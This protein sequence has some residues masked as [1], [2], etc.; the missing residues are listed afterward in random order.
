M[1][2]PFFIFA[3]SMKIIGTTNIKSL[4][5]ILICS[6][7]LLFSPFLT[8]RW[9]NYGAENVIC[10]DI[11]GYYLY[12]PSFFYDDLGTLT[13]YDSIDK[14]YHPASDAKDMA[15][16]QPQTGK[17]VMN[18]PC[19]QAIVELPAFA[20]GHIWAKL[21]GYEVDGFSFPYQMSITIWC[22]LI[23]CLGLWIMRRLLLK[24]FDDWLVA[25]LIVIICTATNF[26]NFVSFSPATHAYL[27]TIYA[28][29]LYLTDIFYREG[30]YK[31]SIVALIGILSGLATIMRP[32]EIIC[33]IIPL[34]WGVKNMTDLKE[35]LAYFF[36]NYKFVIVYSFCA[37]IA[38]LP[39]LIYWKIYSGH[40]LFF[41][42]HGE[43][44]TFNFLHPH[45]LNVLF[46]YKKGWFMYT[47]V[48][49]I[50][51]IGFIQL[52]K[53]FTQ[54]FWALA[55]FTVVN[56][57]LI[58]SWNIWWYGG[59]FSMRPMVQSYPLLMFP[60]GAFLADILRRKYLQYMVSGFLVFCIWLNLMMT[61]QANVRS[62]MCIMEGESMNYAYYWHIFGKTD[63]TAKDKRLLD[64]NEELPERLETKFKLFFSSDLED[65]AF[66]DSTIALS[67][68]KSIKLT[69]DKQWTEKLNVPVD[70][71]IH[72][73]WYRVYASVYY[74][75]MESDIWLQTQFNA[76][77]YKNGKVVKLNM[78]RIQ[79]VSQQ[80]SWQ[81]VYVDI[82]VPYFSNYD[83]FEINFWN[84]GSAKNIYID[85]IKVAYC[86][87]N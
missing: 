12:L 82:K 26:Y 56:I 8:K 59:C 74:P 49:M 30:R 44:K 86:P 38:A 43:D 7:F 73:G 70:N 24:Y 14:I 78:I 1:L 42:Y 20:A 71:K 25:L 54:L 18:Y 66:A 46:S 83:S 65:I 87:E 15:F 77:F 84:P 16:L 10:W 34:L 52:F 68:K 35:R 36:K 33:V 47:P 22:V 2:K 4:T 75:E 55:A 32:T 40:W 62:K 64:T 69:K 9:N 48:M 50:S 19:G 58:S 3:L 57:Y 67:G 61:Y 17:Y 11:Y 23:A 53:K 41:S 21:G 79:R 37:L 13:K 27:F 51:I 45:I 60:M 5:A 6:V 39:Q 76:G 63:V 85:D 80:G 31:L 81:Q 72:K 28:S 29:L